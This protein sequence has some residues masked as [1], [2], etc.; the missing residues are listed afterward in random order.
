MMQVGRNLLDAVDGFLLG[1]KHLILDRD[2][3]YTAQ[4]R[5]LLRDGGVKPVRLP[6]K[7]PNLNAHADSFVRSIREEC[8]NPSCLWVSGICG[9]SYAN[10]WRTITRSATIRGS[11][12][13]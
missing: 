1:K 9:V 7:S 11:G 6:A 8:L 4:F 10:T 5:R 12:T 13:S 3:F 2:P